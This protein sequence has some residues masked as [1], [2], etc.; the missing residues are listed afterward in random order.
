[1]VNGTRTAYIFLFYPVCF[2]ILR[3][4]RVKKLK[5]NWNLF[6]SNPLSFLVPLES[7]NLKSKMTIKMK[8]EGFRTTA[9][10]VHSCLALM[11]IDEWFSGNVQTIFG[12]KE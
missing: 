10:T 8:Q 6:F 2:K 12:Y 5:K 1:M 4:K 11:K 3:T 7:I 9:R